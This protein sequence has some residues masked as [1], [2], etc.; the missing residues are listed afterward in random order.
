MTTR[1][2]INDGIE[3]MPVD[4]IYSPVAVSIEHVGPCHR[5]TFGVPDGEGVTKI[6]ARLILSDEA[7]RAF[8]D[9]IPQYFA[10]LSGNGKSNRPHIV[11][12][13]APEVSH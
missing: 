1:F 12:L 4:D 11:N 10:L 6:S 9:A 13:N 8:L 2:A 3:V 7:L 5:V